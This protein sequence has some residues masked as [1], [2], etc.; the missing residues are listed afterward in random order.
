MSISSSQIISSC[1]QRNPDRPH[2]T[3]S[4]FLLLEI[5]QFKCWKRNTGGLPLKD[6]N[7]GRTNKFEIFLRTRGLELLIGDCNTFDWNNFDEPLKASNMI[8]VDVSDSDP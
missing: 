8:F 1:A 2:M 5:P 4:R 3:I 7:F 6:R